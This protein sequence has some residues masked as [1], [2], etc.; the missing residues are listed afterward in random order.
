MACHRTEAVFYPIAGEIAFRRAA[1]QNSG[2]DRAKYGSWVGP[3]ERIMT[4]QMTATVVGGVFKPHQP[5]PLPE[6][7]RVNLTVEPIVDK[8][9]TGTGWEP[10][11]AWI[12]QNSLHGLGRRL[13]R[14]ELHKRS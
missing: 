8:A 9:E 4:T 10:L 7:T 12:R 11:K 13:T 5:L 2:A 3:E 1:C 14:D 6:Q